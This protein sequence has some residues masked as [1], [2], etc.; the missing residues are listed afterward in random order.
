MA[1][2]P[3]KFNES[4]SSD[5]KVS[6]VALPFFELEYFFTVVVFPHYRDGLNYLCFLHTA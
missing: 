5:F 3:V 2:V 4:L 1:K 6:A